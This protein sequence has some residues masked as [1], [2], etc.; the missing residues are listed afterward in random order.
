M[1]LKPGAMVDDTG[2]LSP[3]A[4][5]FVM[6]IEGCYI[7]VDAVC[8][9]AQWAVFL[10]GDTPADIATE[11]IEMWEAHRLLAWKAEGK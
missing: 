10:D 2:T 1:T 9:C 8:S 4:L 11:V 3:H 6:N 5:G 7:D